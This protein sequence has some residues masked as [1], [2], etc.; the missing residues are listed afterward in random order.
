[1]RG[2]LSQVFAR[3]STEPWNCRCVRH[4]QKKGWTGAGSTGCNCRS[5]QAVRVAHD[6]A[7]K[8]PARKGLRRT[9]VRQ[10]IR[11]RKSPIRRD[12]ESRRCA[13]HKRRNARRYSR[14]GESTVDASLCEAA[15]LMWLT[16]ACH[17]APEVGGYSIK[18][19]C[20]TKCTTVRLNRDKIPSSAATAR[21][22]LFAQP[23]LFRNLLHL[24]APGS[25][26][27]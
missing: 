27:E 7:E 10:K 11:R 1:A 15:A 8:F 17:A 3:R 26:C 6:V 16:R 4:L 2:R 25:S 13:S 19:I 9:E 22:C 5:S 18:R 20:I 21:H 24:P 23:A 14:S 12:A